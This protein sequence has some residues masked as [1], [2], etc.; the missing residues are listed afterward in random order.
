MSLTQPMEYGPHAEEGPDRW[1]RQQQE[2]A[3][4]PGDTPVVALH[5]GEILTLNAYCAR[6]KTQ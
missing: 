3:C 2:L 1:K 6:M 4:L 5:G